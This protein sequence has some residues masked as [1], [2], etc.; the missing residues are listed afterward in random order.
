MTKTCVKCGS[1]EFNKRGD[2]CLPCRRIYAK[3]YRE[4]NKEK[5]SEAKKRAYRA[6]KDQYVTKSNHYQ[7]VNKET[8]YAWSKQYRIE[9]KEKIAA[10]NKAYYEANKSLIQ[11]QKQDYNRRN[12]QVHIN[13]KARRRTR[14]GDDKLS[15]GIFSQLMLDQRGLCN[16]CR[17]EL[18]TVRK[19]VHVDHIMP[20]KLGGRNIDSNVQLL[21][22][23][24]NH[25]K[26][27]K[28]PDVWKSQKPQITSTGSYSSLASSSP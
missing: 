9:N 11:A 21:C 18:G 5:V 24:C 2:D 27:A 19:Y 8:L 25:T 26:H 20:L 3:A 22:S 1:T 6:K 4:A 23:R 13:S 12:P 28:H 16:G 15:R 10:L 14:V 17:T 7:Q